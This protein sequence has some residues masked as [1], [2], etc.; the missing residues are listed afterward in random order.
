MRL[1][2]TKSQEADVSQFK[3]SEYDKEK[4][5]RKVCVM[6]NGC[7]ENRIDCARMNEFLKSNGFTVTTDCKDAD[8]ILF[9]ACALTQ[10][11]QEESI[12]IINLVKA[13]KKHSAK[14]V[15]YGCLPQ[16]NGTRLGEIYQGSTF[17]SDEIEK[18]TEIIDTKTSPEDTFANYLIPSVKV[19]LVRRYSR[20]LKEE[21][22]SLMTIKQKLIGFYYHRL[23]RAINAYNSYTFCIKV[24]TGCLNTCA[25][26]A[27]KLSRGKLRSKPINNVV[28]EFEQGLAEGNTEFALIGT[29][30]GA[31]GR[32]QGTNLST[33][34]R[35]LLRR[36]GDYIIRLRNL[37]PRFLIEMM[38]E[39]REIL[40]CGKIS[41]ISSAVESGNNRILK[42]M[43]R[44][45]KIEDYKQAILTLKRELPKIQMRTQILV[46]FPGETEDEFHDTLRL[47][48]EVGFDFVEVYDFQAR[49]NTAA[50]R[51]KDQVPKKVIKR[52]HYQAQMKSIYIARR[53]RAKR[54][55]KDYDSF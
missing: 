12:D 34:L 43:R 38:P 30:I 42:L 6:T 26:C 51:M 37:H 27:V 31:Y 7:P 1:S 8:I 20:R 16:I 53:T 24:C 17:G 55:H 44:G 46:G 2:G 33:L 41:Y 36:K 9:N 54:K 5:N 14:L 10:T 19:P 39:L 3:E 13:R 45:Y 22:L 15:V 52:R 4:N 32:D 49:P 29:E 21:K 11:T 23:W 50:A 48:D 25:F 28:K 18:I 35:E 47:L 40:R